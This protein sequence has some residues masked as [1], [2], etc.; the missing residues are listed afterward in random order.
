MLTYILL[1]ALSQ[2][3]ASQCETYAPRLDGSVV[4]TC[5]G[6]VTRVRMATRAEFDAMRDA[7]R[8]TFD[9]VR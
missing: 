8:H 9:E 2:N 6:K 1:A 7:A 5:G 4:T 3:A